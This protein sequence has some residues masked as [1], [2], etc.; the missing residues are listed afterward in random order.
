MP[1]HFHAVLK[2][3]PHADSRIPHLSRAMQIFKSLAA[4]DY[5]DLLKAG[6]CPDI[7][8]QLWMRS[9][10]DNLV[11]SYRELEAIRAYIRANPA[12]WEADRFGPVTAHNAGDLELLN[13]PCVAF[14]ASEGGDEAPPPRQY[15][16]EGPDS[17]L[18]GAGLRP[19]PV[20]VSTFSSQQEHAILTACL[21]TRRPYI[22]VM[23]AGIPQPLPP[24][25]A[26][27]CTEGWA[28]ILSPFPPGTA[29]NKQRAIW[30]NQYVLNH[31][32]VVWCGTIRPG[33]TLE[34]LLRL[35]RRHPTGVER[36]FAATAT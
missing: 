20:V 24:T 32:D 23:P 14:V 26:K 33:G 5:L 34:S 1:N 3:H 36:S 27:A 25:W 8:G 15:V 11:S 29:L 16:P 30:C 2:I 21:A 10:Y 19:R 18:V 28:L 7:G 17:S 35:W 12:S 22:H 4:H 9:Y 31:A 13:Q 6:Q